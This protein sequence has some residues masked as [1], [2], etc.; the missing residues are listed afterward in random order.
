MV[1]DIRTDLAKEAVEVWEQGEQAEKLRGVEISSGQVEGLQREVIDILSDEGERSLGKPRG[2]YVTW[3][4]DVM[5]RREEEAFTRSVEALAGELRS[6]LELKEDEGVLVA[7]LGNADITP[8]ALGALAAESVLVT[9]HLKE[10]LPG[11][12]RF[13]RSVSVLRCGVLGT[14]GLESAE[15]IRAAARLSGCSRVIAVD[16][17]CARSTDRLCRTVQLTDAGI[18]PGSGVGNA[19]A[20]LSAETVGCPVVAVGVP[21]VVDAATLC[22]DLTGRA[23]AGGGQPLF[24]TPRNIDSSVR[25]A[26]RLIGYAIDLA[27]HPGMTVG[28]VDTMIG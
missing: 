28:D 6:L 18:V 4:L 25:A 10:Q 14:T 16:A 5:D 8:D 15:L 3:S 20:A 12:F 26:A 27:L 9:K 17:I 21:T 19:R 23:P 7:A 24:V 22:A 1:Y 2:R 13:F 11:E